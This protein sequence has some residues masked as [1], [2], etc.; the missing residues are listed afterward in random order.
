MRI[1]VLYPTLKCL[2]NARPCQSTSAAVLT[3]ACG[4]RTR[5]HI[6]RLG[7]SANL[8]IGFGL[9]AVSQ[10]RGTSGRCLRYPTF[11]RLTRQRG[12][13]GGTQD[14]NCRV[15]PRR[16]AP[17]PIPPCARPIAPWNVSLSTR[18]RRKSGPDQSTKNRSREWLLPPAARKADYEPKYAR[19]AFVAQSIPAFAPSDAAVSLAFLAI[20]PS[21]SLTLAP[22]PFAPPARSLTSAS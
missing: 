7:P 14:S 19:S 15:T 1:W 6:G 11:S 13:G 5:I 3:P 18:R 22:M 8:A 12:P 17:C 21:H 16:S 9:S 2:P 4:T 20:P 10:V